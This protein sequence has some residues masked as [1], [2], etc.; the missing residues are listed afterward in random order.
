M[1]HRRLIAVIIDLLHT[2]AAPVSQWHPVRADL[3]RFHFNFVI[4]LILSLIVIGKI[5]I[6][7]SHRGMQGLP[8]LRHP[9]SRVIV[10]PPG[11]PGAALL[12]SDSAGNSGRP[13]RGCASEQSLPVPH[14]TALPP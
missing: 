1:N 6:A 4:S 14:W 11:S 9:L 10:M 2:F 8:K 5:A 3:F 13:S 7:E 12:F